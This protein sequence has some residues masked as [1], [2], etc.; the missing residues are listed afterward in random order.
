MRS[1]LPAL[2]TLL[3]C[4]ANAQTPTPEILP[5]TIN[6]TVLPSESSEVSLN[7]EPLAVETCRTVSDKAMAADLK[8]LS[9]KGKQEMSEQLQLQNTSETLWSQ[10]ISLCEGRAKDRAERNLAESVKA[11]EVLKEQLGNGPAC[12]AAHKDASTLQELARTAL[13]ERRW[14][15]SASLFRKSEDMWEV[16][17]ERCNGS[18]KELA[19]RRREQTEI[20]GFNAENCAPR[21]D[22]ARDYIQKLRTSSAGLTREEKQENLM[23]AE[24]LWREATDQCKGAAAQDTARNNAQALGRERGTPWVAKVAVIPTT[25]KP[26]S[27]MKSTALSGASALGAAI[28]GVF[29]S[30]PPSAQKTESPPALGPVASA[31][32]LATPVLAAPPQ[33]AILKS[34][35]TPSTS[36]RTAM[37]AD[38]I[39]GSMRMQ[40]DFTL[41]ASG[42]SYSGNGQVTWTNGDRYEGSLKENKRHGKGIFVWANGHRYDGHWEQDEPTGQAAILF[43][44]GNQYEGSAVNGVPQ[45]NGKML[46]ATGDHYNGEFDRGTPHGA[47][48]Y[49]WKNGQ[50]YVGIFKDSKPHGQGS[51]NYTNG[52]RYEGTLQNGVPDQ[53]GTFTWANGDIYT[54]QWKN[55]IKDGQGTLKWATGDRWEGVYASDAQTAN[56]SLIRK[57]P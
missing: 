4:F 30:A 6:N 13:S 47:G 8:A 46:Y 15:D 49:I 10:A 20:D 18:Q 17:T 2:L 1:C 57:A 36:P 45:G 14:A 11:S 50:R 5:T 29:S 41:D 26:Q 42:L 51:M 12:A 3:T 39:T 21:F 52:D 28:S 32:V 24:T 23:K 31:P 16:A 48:T 35:S 7:T 25:P 44:N 9:S 37:P 22:K 43:A 55:G 38:F 56:G 33:A 27:T 34:T 53:T 19:N 40:G 54:G